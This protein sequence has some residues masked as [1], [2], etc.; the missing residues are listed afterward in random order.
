MSI[1]EII[2][3]IISFAISTLI[4][5]A[6][7]LITKHYFKGLHW[8]F[9]V[10]PLF[11]FLCMYLTSNSDSILVN[12]KSVLLWGFIFCMLYV[13]IVCIIIGSKRTVKSG[14][15]FFAELKKVREENKKK[16][17]EKKEMDG[18]N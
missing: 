8:I 2:L 9:P 6:Y 18:N 3:L 12:L 13:N 17:S 14:K 16:K 15:G 10:S 5:I 11:G 1:D 7:K 4:V